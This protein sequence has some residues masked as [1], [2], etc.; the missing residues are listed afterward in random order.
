MRKD[1]KRRRMGKREWEGKEKVGREIEKIRKGC[2]RAVNCTR[3]YLIARV[4]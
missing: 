1:E 3:V 4:Q 2:A